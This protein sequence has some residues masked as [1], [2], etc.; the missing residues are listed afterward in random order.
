MAEA[1]RVIE[2][3]QQNENMQ[4]E[5]IMKLQDAESKIEQLQQV[6][7]GQHDSDLLTDLTEDS[8]T[9]EMRHY[10]GISQ[11]TGPPTKDAPLQWEMEEARLKVAF[12]YYK[13]WA[14]CV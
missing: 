13:D 5:L 4:E 8:I 14:V 9:L 10:R 2:E 1:R 7:T 3:S 6:R 11:T 12:L